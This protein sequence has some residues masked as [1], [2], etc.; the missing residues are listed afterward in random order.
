ML[1]LVTFFQMGASAKEKKKK[2]PAPL[3][4]LQYIITHPTLTQPLH[5]TTLNITSLSTTTVPRKTSTKLRPFHELYN[6]PQPPPLG[7]SL[8]SVH[9]CYSSH[10]TSISQPRAPISFHPA[11]LSKAEVSGR[12]LGFSSLFP[13]PKYDI[14]FFMIDI[15]TKLF[16]PIFLPVLS[17]KIS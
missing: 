2:I 17:D 5:L 16:L 11:T 15:P 13:P 9:S 4:K 8:T 6:T 7:N 12:M 10:L 3:I 1:F 14:Y